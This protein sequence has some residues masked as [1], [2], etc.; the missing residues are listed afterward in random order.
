MWLQLGLQAAGGVTD[1]LQA[2]RDAKYKRRLQEYNNKMVRLADAQNQNAITTNQNIAVEAS[3]AKQ[4]AIDRQRYLTE[5]EVEVAAAASDTAGR[6]VNQTL[7]QVQRSADEADSNRQRELEHQLAS[8]SQQRLNSA[9]QAQQQ[10]DISYIPKPSL[11]TSALD[12]GTKLYTTHD[13]ITNP[14]K[15]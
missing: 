5:G 3:V 10:L 14:R 1:F 6:S 4:F 13:R 7:Y 11:I 9:M 15:I 8:F 2:S 12:I